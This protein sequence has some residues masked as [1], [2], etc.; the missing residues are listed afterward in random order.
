MPYKLAIFDFDGTL[1]DSISWVKGILAPV[2]QRFRFRCPPPEELEAL[3]GLDGRAALS[4]LGISFWKLPL[5]ALHMRKLAARDAGRISLYPGVTTLLAE[6][7]ARGIGIAIVSSNSEDNVR[8]ILGEEAA[9][10]I[11]HYACGASVFGKR[12][13]FRAVLKRARISP[14][15]AIAIGDEVRDI[16]AAAAEGIDTVAV[17]WGYATIDLL[18]AH[19]ASSVFTTIDELLSAVVS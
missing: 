2:A 16:K 15:D 14:R 19:G 10:R 12:S 13:C 5:I 7:E 4:R 1:A 11:G 3:R 8:R 18:R 17:A 9:S 6:L